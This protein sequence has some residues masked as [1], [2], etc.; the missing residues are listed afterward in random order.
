[1]NVYFI[2]LTYNTN[3][4]LLTNN[5]DV[6]KEQHVIIV[7]NTEQEHNKVKKALSKKILHK[8]QLIE[9]E[10]NIGYA[11][12]MNKG[13]KSAWNNGADWCV[14]LNDD[15]LLHKKNIKEIIEGIYNKQPA[16]LGPEGGILEKN[17]W[18]TILLSPQEAKKPR[19]HVDYISGSCFIVHKQVMDK[20]HGFFPLFFMYY[21]DVDASIEAKRKG[22]PIALL[23]LSEFVHTS[24]NSIK[25]GSPLHEYYLARNHLL[26]IER[27]APIKIKLRELIRLPKTVYEHYMFNKAAFRGVIDFMI[28]R[29]GKASIRV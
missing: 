26:F 12:G 9:N 27:Q 17:R 24:G 14:L 28:T 29:F 2:I 20:L 15:I 16:I 7:D 11:S 13:M 23:P 5:L 21:E 25:K 10:K 18:T 19:T 22:F 8:V 4:Q 3:P 1:M 6:L